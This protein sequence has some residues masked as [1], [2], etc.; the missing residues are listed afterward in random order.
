MLISVPQFIGLRLP[1]LSCLA[2]EFSSVNWVGFSFTVVAGVWFSSNI[3]LT[4]PEH[5][6]YSRLRD[7]QSGSPSTLLNVVELCSHPIAEHDYSM[8]VYV[9]HVIRFSDLA[10]LWVI[11]IEKPM[12]LCTHN[13]SRPGEQTTKCIWRRKGMQKVC[14]FYGQNNNIE[15]SVSLSVVYCQLFKA[16]RRNAQWQANPLTAFKWWR[17]SVPV[18]CGWPTH[19]GIIQEVSLLSFL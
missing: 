10:D 1:L 9:H 13:T 11:K 12:I 5:F 7:K 2:H 16:V 17:K 14:L 8:L 4:S 3:R 18:H 6:Y 15:N 19:P